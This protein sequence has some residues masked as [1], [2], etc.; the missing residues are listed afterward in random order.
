MTDLQKAWEWREKQGLLKQETGRVFHG[1]VEGTGSF[2]G[3]MIDRFGSRYW[4][5]WRP[6]P[7]EANPPWSEEVT[8][9]LKE[10]G[11]QAIALQERPLRAAP[12]E[13]RMMYGSVPAEGFVVH[14]NNLRFVVRFTHQ[15]HPGLFLDH[16]PQRAWLKENMKGLS[17]LNTFAYTGSLSVAAGAGG[18]VS[19]TTLDLSKPSIEWAK[20]NWEL[21]S[22]QSQGEFIA[23]DVFERLPRWKRQ[24]R[25][26]DGVILDPPSFSRGS[27]GT[28]SVLKDLRMLHTLALEVLKKDGILITSL[29]AVAMTEASYWTAVEKSLSDL[30]RTHQII[31]PIK[32]PETFPCRDQVP[33]DRYLKGWILRVG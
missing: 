3:L 15:R 7:K 30:G 33:D 19:V 11:A 23:G 1:P 31:Q 21:N 9:F 13:C 20:Q 22:P 27:K 17:V 10:K 16:A 12:D 8:Q 18:A 26:F 32:L 5:S 25:L 2:Q 4:L 6:I 29:N 28:F 14:E 24:G